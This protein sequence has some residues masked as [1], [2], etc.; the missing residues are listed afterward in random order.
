MPVQKPRDLKLA[1]V[2]SLARKAIESV[3]IVITAPVS[4]M[5]ITIRTAIDWCVP[6]ATDHDGR[7][8]DPHSQ[9][10]VCFCRNAGTHTCNR[11]CSACCYE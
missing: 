5:L 3:T 1:P 6:E 8:I 10:R 4:A 7:N 9:I 11:K 2:P